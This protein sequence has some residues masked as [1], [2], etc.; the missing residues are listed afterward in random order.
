MRR[1]A[2]RNQ[3]RRG[4]A[5]LEFA[6][7]WVVLFPVLAG[8]YQFGYAYYLF[9]NLE[10]NTRA[11]ARYA[12]IR[13]YDSTSATPTAAYSTAVK[14]MLVYGS[15]SATDASRPVAPGLQPD[16]VQVTMQFVK[17]IPSQVSVDV[18]GYTINGVFKKFTLQ[19]K[20]KATYPY[21]GRWD[22][23]P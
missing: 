19:G 17:G 21:I 11:A 8:V 22:P 12:A 13:T 5:L 10:S 7:G 2:P 14:N 4:N 18:A 20:P 15:V 1:N 6:L 16:N 3:R 23:V 9:N